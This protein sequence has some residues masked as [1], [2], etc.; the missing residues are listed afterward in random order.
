[1]PR[2]HAVPVWTA[3]FGEAGCIGALKWM[4]LLGITAKQI[5]NFFFELVIPNATHLSDVLDLHA[6]WVELIFFEV[7][8]KPVY[9]LLGARLRFTVWC[10]SLL[11]L[12]SFK[13]QAQWRSWAAL[14]PVRKMSCC[15]TAL[16]PGCSNNL[17]LCLLKL[18][19]RGRQNLSYLWLY[20][21][22]KVRICSFR[23][24]LKT[25]AFVVLCSLWIS[26]WLGPSWVFT[27]HLIW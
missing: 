7:I 5:I 23:A 2:L 18:L 10:R 16:S 4:G 19:P 20:K 12:I 22:E 3:S 21:L 14:H 25:G 9:A 26:W 11:S 27:Y 17:R 8:K 6:C 24:A 1:M 15:N 13:V